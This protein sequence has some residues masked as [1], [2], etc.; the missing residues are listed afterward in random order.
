MENGGQNKH[1]VATRALSDGLPQM[2]QQRAQTGENTVTWNK[3]NHIYSQQ[4]P[5][6]QQANFYEDEYKRMVSRMDKMVMSEKNIK[7]VDPFGELLQ[8]SVLADEGDLGYID[9]PTPIP[10]PQIRKKSRVSIHSLLKWKRYQDEKHEI[11]MAMMQKL[12][13]MD[14]EFYRRKMRKRTQL[15]TKMPPAEFLIDT[16]PKETEGHMRSFR[17][18]TSEGDSSMDSMPDGDVMRSSG[19]EEDLRMNCLKEEEFR[20]G[21]K[22]GESSTNK[23]LKNDATQ[24]VIQ[25]PAKKDPVS[26]CRHFAKGWCRQG[27]ACSF[28][29][30]VKDSYPTSQKVFLGGLPHSM[31][32]SKLLQDLKMLGY[33]VIN[34]P[35]VF[36]GFSPQVCLASSAQATKMLQ[37]KKI[38]ICGCKVEVR[39][40][41]AITKKEQDRQLEIN[42]RSVFLGGLPTSVTFQMLKSTVEKMGM[43]ITNRPLIKAGFIPKVTLFSTE[44]AQKL[45]AQATIDINGTIV[46]VRPY[47]SKNHLTKAYEV[48]NIDL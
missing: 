42:K 24:D 35:K 13:E 34:R 9:G 39:P 19:P 45:V 25:N 12:E 16:L 32:T 29:H 6:P 31:T 15:H 48:S 38:I 36:R 46:N 8:L 43:K 44:Q 37:E 5:S 10:P 20:I 21:C 3:Y 40:Y 22:S 17:S 7:T 30:S 28:Q 18:T 14:K 11:F 2:S 4:L 33:E 23:Q 27:D 47:E 26:A 1:T 41:K